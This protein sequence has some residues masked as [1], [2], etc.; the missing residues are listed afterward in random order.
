MLSAKSSI[1][2]NLEGQADLLNGLN[3][4]ITGVIWLKKGS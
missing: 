4:A 1:K 3:G 2:Q